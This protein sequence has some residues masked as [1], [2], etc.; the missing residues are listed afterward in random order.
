MV[1]GGKQ[2]RSG[3]AGIFGDTVRP[4]VLW[5]P[6]S[7]LLL[8]IV[9]SLVNEAGFFALVSGANGIILRFFAP[10]FNWGSFAFLLTLIWVWFSPL[11]R[12]R[13]GGA[14]AT[15]LLS[16]WNWFAITLCTTIAI[17]ILF[18]ATAEPMYHFHEPPALAEIEPA[19]D[20]ARRFAIS[21]LFMHWAFTPYAIY[22]VPSLAFALAYH[23]LGKGYSL[24]APLALVM[25]GVS[26]R[27]P[28]DLIDA[29]ALFALAAGI[30]ASLGVG[31]LSIAQGLATAVAISGGA[32]LQGLVAIAIVGA[33]MLSSMSGLMRGIRVLSDWN[34]RFFFVLC[35]FLLLAGPTGEILMGMGQGALDYGREFLPRSLGLGAGGDEAWGRAWTSFYWAN[36]L[37]WAPVTAMFL[38]RIARGYTVRQ[39]ILFNL[40]L[41]SLFAIGWMSIFGV[42][43]IVADQSGGGL[44]DALQANGPE[45]V[46]Y[47]LFDTLPAGAVW[48]GAFVL[49]SFL[50]FVTAADSN[51]EA[52]ASLCRRDEGH[53]SFREEE[54]ASETLRL[55]VL[56]ACLIG[57]TAWIMVTFS[58]VDGVRMLSNLGGLPA[59]FIILF[60]NAA[61]ILM[62]TR[63]IH[64]LK[65]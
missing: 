55:K 3:E 33:F 43:A 37:A 20:E 59:L 2:A 28:R 25:P 6:L 9:A 52:I 51:T 13:I 35:G 30:S 42:S 12:V 26:G 11:G 41:P 21:S 46:I 45:A 50:C 16:K 19:S 54:R 36:W 57:A 10:L 39:F 48:G 8:G 64:L 49:L 62:A 14:H 44:Y 5:L 24:S 31:I 38:G 47:A 34:I 27:K 32:L 23:N 60:M 58:G 7:L 18:W 1:A 53:P 40:I 17:G 15:P 61:L 22:T 56:W 65:K 4:V 29:I 63:K